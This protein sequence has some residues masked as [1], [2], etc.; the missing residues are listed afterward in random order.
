M[1]SVNIAIKIIYYL[2]FLNLFFD[3][4]LRDKDIVKINLLK[5]ICFV[6][7]INIYKIEILQILS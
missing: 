6:Y 5:K 2:Y 3:Y 7:I 1:K 4:T